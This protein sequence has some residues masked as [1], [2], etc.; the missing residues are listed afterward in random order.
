MSIVQDKEPRIVAFDPLSV[1][2][3]DAYEHPGRLSSI[4]ITHVRSQV[5]PLAVL[6]DRLQCLHLLAH[7]AFQGSA[8]AQVETDILRNFGWNRRATGW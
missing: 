3:A 1:G 5:T 7:A 8:S 2:I 4:H 6:R